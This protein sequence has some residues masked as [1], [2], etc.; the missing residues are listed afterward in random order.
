MV[1]QGNVFALGS[2]RHDLGQGARPEAEGA[3]NDSGLT[4][5][6][7]LESE[8]PSLA[9]AQRAHDLEALDRGVSRLQRLEA[10]HGP[11]RQVGALSVFSASGSSQSFNPFRAL[12]RNR[13]AALVLRVDER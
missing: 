4:D 1:R 11:E 10:A 12:P 8:Y 5:D 2:K 13:F 6:A 3:L 9:L 7:V